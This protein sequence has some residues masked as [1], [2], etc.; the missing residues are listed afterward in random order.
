MQVDRLPYLVVGDIAGVTKRP[1]SFLLPSADLLPALYHQSFGIFFGGFPH[2]LQ[3]EL[4]AILWRRL[5][6]LIV[7]QPM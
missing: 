4:I 6:G 5:P 7:V 2:Y 3:A 1:P